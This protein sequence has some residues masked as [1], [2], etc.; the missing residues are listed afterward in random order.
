MIEMITIPTNRTVYASLNAYSLLAHDVLSLLDSRLM[1]IYDEISDPSEAALVHGFDNE[2]DYFKY[3]MDQID[4]II[5]S[6]IGYGSDRYALV[7][8][9]FTS[10]TAYPVS[11]R[12]QNG[13][14]QIDRNTCNTIYH[15]L[16]KNR[17]KSYFCYMHI[18]DQMRR[19][20][21]NK[22]VGLLINYVD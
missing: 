13:G 17:M 14:I 10:P 16:E 20:V 5:Y 19:V 15:M 3:A 1:T 4:N 21:E 11:L 9:M 22:D 8:L 7:K 12:E 2:A 6:E 18:L